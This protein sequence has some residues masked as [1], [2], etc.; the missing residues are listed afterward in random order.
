MWKAVGA[1]LRFLKSL[2]LRVYFSKIYLTQTKKF[3]FCKNSCQVWNVLMFNLKI[4]FLCK[5]PVLCS[6]HHLP[7]QYNCLNWF[8]KNEIKYLETEEFIRIPM[9]TDKNLRC[10]VY[11]TT[12]FQLSTWNLPFKSLFNFWSPRK[13]RS[14]RIK[15]WQAFFPYNRVTWQHNAI[16]LAYCGWN[17]TRE[18][19]GTPYCFLQKG[20]VLGGQE[21][22][23]QLLSLPPHV[24]IF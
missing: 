4:E 3:S 12:A 23:G 24:V 8:D 11:A 2:N 15:F 7:E 14:Y 6:I 22:R 17:S 20:D 21:N 16:F 10:L 1:L 13:K 9:T 5:S 18:Q 19:G